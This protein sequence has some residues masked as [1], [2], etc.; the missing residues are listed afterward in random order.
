MAKNQAYKEYEEK[1]YAV[2]NASR[3]REEDVKALFSELVSV[4]PNGGK[5]YKYK[6]LDSF[7]IDE[8]EEKYVW[9]SSAKHLN[10]NKDCTFNANVL[11]EMEKL[12][13]FF[14][15]DNNFRKTL[16]NGFYLELVRYNSDI[17]PEIVDDC[18]NCITRNGNRVGKLKYTSFCQKYKLTN[19]QKQKLLNTVALYRD[20]QQCE[21]QIRKRISNFVAQTEEIRD[22]MQILSLTTSYKKDSMWAYYCNNEGICIE[23]DFSKITSFEL[24]KLFINTQMVRYGKKKKFSYVD[25]MKARME[26]DAAALIKADTMIMEQVLTKDKSWSTEEEWR[27]ILNDRGNYVGRKVPIDM[28]SAIY[29]DFSV[30]ETDKAKKIIKMAKE[31]DWQIYIRYFSRFEAEYRYDTIEKTNKFLAKTK[32]ITDRG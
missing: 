16:I 9:F 5:L 27:V 11:Q 24:Q 32:F 2:T 17:T 15:K 30:F 21:E 4:L 7:H 12:I 13:R 23:Y 26:N 18:F 22:S 14:L 6:P 20:D 31:N 10:D 3:L 29:M 28:I 25:V 8:L 1:L 19:A